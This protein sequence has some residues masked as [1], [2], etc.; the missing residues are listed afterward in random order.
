MI[1][2]DRAS[3]TVD[4]RLRIRTW[5][6]GLRTLTGIDASSAVGRRYTDFFPPF[7][8]R[9]SEAVASVFARSRAV[10]LRQR[11][12]QCLPRYQ[13]VDVRLAPLRENGGGI[14]HVQIDMHPSDPQPDSAFPDADGQKLIAIGKIAAT[15]AHGVRNPLNAIKGAVVYLR[16]RYA[17][18]APL[19]EFTEILTAEIARLEN[20]ISRFLGTSA[21]DSDTAFVDINEL[22]G[23]IK[24]F[25]SLQTYAR[26]IRC[27]YVLEDVPPIEI[28]PFHLEQAL[29][30]VVNN[31]IEAMGEGGS[32]TVRT[33]LRTC[34]FEPCV[35]IE[36]VD[37]GDGISPC[38]HTT[39]AGDRLRTTGR[40]FGLFIAD[41]I[42]KYWHGQIRIT[43]S[44]GKGT[45]VTFLLP[46]P[47][48]ANGDTS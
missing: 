39:A 17:R 41:E 31:A 4:R 38:L 45:T 30:N 23:K 18:E 6:D 15:L 34:S 2:I 13:L 36:V 26:H 40:G 12:F 25:I 35:A 29:L 16:D 5:S 3:F 24:V 10:R 48:G 8:S 46:V 28:S 11:T 33:S 37:S 1:Q 43:G 44:P 27:A 22:I 32:L 20:F 21:F 19:L 42:L 14:R 7:V 47:S 9:K